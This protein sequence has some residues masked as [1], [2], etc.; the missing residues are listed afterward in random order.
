MPRGQRKPLEEKIKEKQNLIESL[1]VRIKSEERELEELF[2]QRKKEELQMV[3]DLI[4]NANLTS[5][6][7]TEALH[8]Y[9]QSNKTKVS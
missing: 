2:E 7:V 3:S 9:I 5:K 4:E 1:N 6:E 8:Q